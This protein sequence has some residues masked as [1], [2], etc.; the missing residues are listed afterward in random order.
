MAEALSFSVLPLIGRVDDAG[1][2]NQSRGEPK[3]N[4]T[5][6]ILDVLPQST[7]GRLLRLFFR[8]N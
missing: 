3:Q 6:T 8:D 7:R 4:K 1:S 2:L 5:K